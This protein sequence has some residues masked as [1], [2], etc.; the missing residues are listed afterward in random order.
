M[1]LPHTPGPWESECVSDHCRVFVGAGRRKII[2]ARLAPKQ[3]PENETA[4]N[5]RLMAASLELL[6]VAERAISLLCQMPPDKIP[7]EDPIWT[8]WVALKMKLEAQQ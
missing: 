4:V 5:G 7:I 1:N 6:S 3:L 2:L 8:D